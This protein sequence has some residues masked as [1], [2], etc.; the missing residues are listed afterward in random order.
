MR[1]KLMGL[2]LILAC[3]LTIKSNA[4]DIAAIKTNLVMDATLNANLGVEVGLAPNWSLDVTGE[5][6]AWNMSHQRKWKHWY[7]Q[8][9]ARYWLCD[10]FAGHFFGVHLFGGQYNLAK[11][12]ADFTLLGTDYNNLKDTRY[13]GW[14]VGA[15]VAYGYA[16]A[17]SKHWNIEGEIGIG[18]AYSRYDRFK[19]SGC[20]K[21][22]EED[23][24][25]HYVG[26]TKAAVNL[27]Y[28]F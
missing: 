11:I 9:E 1:L 12:G 4:Q 13:Q 7:V 24:S 2:F 5:M 28:L 20:G 26:P 21:K 17:L 25:H 23:K 6:N 16:W 27:V 19:C 10:R 3:A 15:G 18:W 14:M 8:P 22:I